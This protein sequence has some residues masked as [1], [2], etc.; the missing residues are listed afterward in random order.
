LSSKVTDPLCSDGS[1]LHDLGDVGLY[2]IQFKP[3]ACPPC[4]PMRLVRRFSHS[5]KKKKLAHLSLGPETG[6]RLLL[7]SPRFHPSLLALAW[8][9]RNMTPPSHNSPGG[10][11][12]CTWHN[13]TLT[14]QSWIS[15]N[16][17]LTW[18]ARWEPFVA[19]CAFR[20]HGL[21]IAHLGRQPMHAR[22]AQS[23][24]VKHADGP[25]MHMYGTAVGVLL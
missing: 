13:T 23:G 7:L 11:H 3:P 22:N 2:L 12:G 25:H 16:T 1:R 21:A 20:A 14:L 10:R 5:K 8:C 18:D 9:P 15:R 19:V 24:S 17:D 4:V 6:R